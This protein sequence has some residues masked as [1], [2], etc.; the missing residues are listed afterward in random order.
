MM[1]PVPLLETSPTRG[2]EGW[3]IGRPLVHRYVDLLQ[4]TMELESL[5]ER[6]TTFTIQLPL[7]RPK[8]A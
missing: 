3:E 8:S 7:R 1:A 5:P 6:G 4:G 2:Y